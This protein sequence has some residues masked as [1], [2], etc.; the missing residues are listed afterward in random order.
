MVTRPSMGRRQIV[1][2]DEEDAYTAW[3]RLY[4]YTQ[5]AGAVAYIKRRTHK[6]ERREARAQ[7]KKELNS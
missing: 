7:I 2:W 3:R 4:A 6:R 1:H 5:K